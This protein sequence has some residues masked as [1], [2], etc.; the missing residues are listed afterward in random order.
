[1]RIFV[2]ACD[3]RSVVYDGYTMIIGVMRVEVSTCKQRWTREVKQVETR[4]RGEGGDSGKQ[5]SPLTV[6]LL[7]AP[8][9]IS[10]C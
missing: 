4:L 5:F 6:R 7:F 8:P 1:M 2:D 3:K 10:L 9:D